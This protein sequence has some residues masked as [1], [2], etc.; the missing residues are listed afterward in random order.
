VLSR[1]ATEKDVVKLGSQI[2]ADLVKISEESR[3]GQTQ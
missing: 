2:A 1:K 3:S